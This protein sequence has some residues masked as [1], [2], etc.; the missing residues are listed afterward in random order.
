M[1]VKNLRETINGGEENMSKLK[2][3]INT[4]FMKDEEKD[5]EEEKEEEEEEEEAV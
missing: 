4:Y 5:T 3:L 1:R 2:T